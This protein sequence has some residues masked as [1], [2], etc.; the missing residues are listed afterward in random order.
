MS[1]CF[2]GLNLLFN[3]SLVI[4]LLCPV[5]G[6]VPEGTTQRLCIHCVI[7]PPAATK[8]SG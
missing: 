3:R 4:V 7:V 5:L 6:V 8:Y 1:F 2:N